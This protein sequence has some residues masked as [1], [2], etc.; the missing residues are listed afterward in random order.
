MDIEKKYKEAIDLLSELV[1]LIDDYR[2]ETYN[3][4]SFTLQ[5]AKKFLEKNKKCIEI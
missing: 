5:P 3:I 2:N 4:D 1:N